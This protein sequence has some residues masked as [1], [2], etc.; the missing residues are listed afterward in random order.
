MRAWA[1]LTLVV[2]GGC[3]VV[4]PPDGVAPAG[5]M[6]GGAAGVTGRDVTGRDAG[7]T[8]RD[9]GATGGD[10]GATGGNAGA[11][12]RDAGATGGSAGVA[13][14]SPAIPEILVFADALSGFWAVT[15]SSSIDLEVGLLSGVT[16]RYSG[17]ARD[18]DVCRLRRSADTLR[19]TCI[20][21]FSPDAEGSV[22]DAHISLRWWSGPA[23]VIFRGDW[24][25]DAGIA[26]QLTGGM[27]GLS[28]T[29]AIPA[30]LHKLAPQPAGQRRTAA[31]MQAV[32]DDL[33]QGV[34]TADR[35]EGIAPKRIAP[36]LSWAGAGQPWHRLRYLAT[37]HIRW[38]RWQRE[39]LQDVY[40]VDSP[41][42]QSL[43]RIAI[44]DSGRVVD[45]ACQSI[46]P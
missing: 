12:G 32:L 11:T 5:R 38:H 39:T 20:A 42:D 2:L 8:G 14:A 41:T 44:G 43:C 25:W 30:T 29:G 4:L 26:G 40:A 34:L 15:A 37:I 7:A 45:F 13:G 10:A 23:T 31:L 46:A 17:E 22:D 19:A 28:V 27:A 36:T 9:A 6:D 35:Y 16:I 1:A 21:G 33:R 18:R 3:T 24:D